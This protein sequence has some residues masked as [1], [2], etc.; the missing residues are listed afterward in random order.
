MSGYRGSSRDVVSM[1]MHRATGSATVTFSGGM[2]M[3]LPLDP[4][5]FGPTSQVESATYVAAENQLV[6]ETTRGDSIVIELPTISEMVPLENRRVVYLDQRDWSTLSKA[7]YAP[8]RVTGNQRAAAQDLMQLVANRSVILPM[9]S[10]HMAETCQWTH[11]DAR[12]ELAL[13]ILQFSAGW[14]MRNP[15]AVRRNEISES[16]LRFR[17]MPTA[18]SP[19][20]TLEPNAVLESS[21]AAVID[22]ETAPGASADQLAK[23]Q[24]VASAFQAMAGIVDTMLDG[25]HVALKPPDGWVE[26]QQRFTGLLAAEN[27]DSRQKRKIINAFFLNDSRFELAAV[28]LKSGLGAAE[29]EQW[30]LTQSE[31]EIA[32]MP[33]FGLFREVMVEKHLNAGIRWK[34][35]DLTDIM[36]LTC[37]AAYSDYIVCEGSLGGSL[38]SGLRRLGRPINV[39]RSLDEL[40]R[41]L[42]NART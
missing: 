29:F 27:R 15:L 38:K 34:K 41:Q 12:Y 24:L 9:S 6:V 26:G 22:E 18:S 3:S 11:G 31:S 7:V 4:N 10:A 16:F 37:G 1:A 36:Y 14:Q 13:T 33:A 21:I 19:V 2:A 5:P 28:A 23:M 17:D 42:I 35:N 8:H 40:V 39:M 32:A 20:I 30:V 25:E